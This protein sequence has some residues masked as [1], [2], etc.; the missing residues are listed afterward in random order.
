MKITSFP[1]LYRNLKRWRQ[2]L[3]VLRRY[4]LADWLS[5]FPSLPMRELLKDK[6]GI[7]LADYSREKRV[8]LALTELGPTFIKLGQILAARPDLVGPLMADELQQLRANVAPDAP[9]VLRR[10]L[11]AELGD[12]FKQEIA[13]LDD[14]PLATASIGQVHAARL[15]DG[16][17]VVIKV[18][19]DGI[20]QVVLQDLDILTGIAQLAERVETFA[21]WGPTEIARQ[22]IPMMRR[23]LDFQREQQNMQLFD[24]FFAKEPGIVVP[25]P[26]PALCSRRVL[27]MRRVEGASIAKWDETDHPTRAAM[28]EQLTTY[29]MRMIFDLGLFHAD[30]HP[31]NLLVLPDG[32]LGILD[33]G[34]VGRLDDRLREAIEEMLYAISAG[35]QAMLLRLV[36]RVGEAGPLLDDSAL[37]VDIGDYIGTYGRQGLGSFDL[38]MALND[39]S[40]ILHRHNVK[41]PSQSALLIKTLVSLEGSLRLLEADFDSLEVISRFVRRAMLRRLSPRRRLRQARRIYMEAEYFLEMAPDQLL[42]MLEQFRRGTAS[43]NLEHRRLSPSVNRLV[44]GLLASSLF[45]GSSFLLAYRVPPLLFPKTPWMGM[46]ELSLFGFSGAA[47]SLIVMLRLLL[48]IGRSGHLTR[49]KDD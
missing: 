14:V 21:A 24:E 37:S 28:A 29:Y 9:D 11:V 2:I 30:P 40:E 47:I 6:H 4:G 33:F 44:L 26:I 31:G 36:K 45:L 7:P 34:M 10:N 43:L 27:V 46:H 3:V 32:R 18:Q 38:S 12:R 8:R 23:E 5:H 49:D 42:G 41:L 16:S 48:A 15:T 20:E 25:Q 1:Q 39:L 35:D 22:I 17:E 13:E 19:R